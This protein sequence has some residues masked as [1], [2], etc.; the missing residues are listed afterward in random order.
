M[1]NLI[2]SVLVSVWK[3]EKNENVSDLVINFTAVIQIECCAQLCYLQLYLTRNYKLNPARNQPDVH[4][5]VHKDVC[6]DMQSCIS[7]QCGK[8]Y[9]P[10]KRITMPTCWKPQEVEL[11]SQLPNIINF[12][13]LIPSFLVEWTGCSKNE[14]Q[15]NIS[16]PATLISIVTTYTLTDV[17]TYKTGIQL[18]NKYLQFID[19]SHRSYSLVSIV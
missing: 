7:A 9:G 13:M 17:L 5:N 2:Q 10:T 11:C 1:Q 12:T 8:H 18:M 16:V 14:D 6:Q 3:S 19:K 4:L 15:S